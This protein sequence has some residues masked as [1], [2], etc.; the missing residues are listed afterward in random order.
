MLRE[1]NEADYAAI[2]GDLREFGLIAEALSHAPEPLLFMELELPGRSPGIV[3]EPRET[4][5][6]GDY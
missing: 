2:E 4:W 6:V 3:A 1:Q 5:M